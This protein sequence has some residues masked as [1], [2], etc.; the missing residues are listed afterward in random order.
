MIIYLRSLSLRLLLDDVFS[1]RFFFLRP[2]SSYSSSDL[3]L[4]SLYSTTPRSLYPPPYPSYS[5]INETNRSLIEL[6]AIFFHRWMNKSD[7]IWLT[8]SFFDFWDFRCIAYITIFTSLP[9][10][11]AASSTYPIIST[12]NENIRYFLR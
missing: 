10:Y 9:I 12:E 8:S 5:Y 7:L 4:V 3:S 11:I 6:F 1:S 2:N